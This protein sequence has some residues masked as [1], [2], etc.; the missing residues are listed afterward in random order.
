M[1]PHFW[2]ERWQNGQTG[3]H[4]GQGNALLR[5]HLGALGL[6]AGARVFVPLCG[7][8]RDIAWLLAQGFE[9]VGAELSRLAIGELFA[10]LGVVPQI[11]AAGAM[12]RYAAPGLTVYVGDIFDLTAAQLGPVDASYDRAALVALPAP[13]RARYAVHLAAI[14]AHSRQ[15]LITFSYDQSLI[16]GPPFSVQAAEVARLYGADYT[17]SCLAD[18]PAR[19]GIRGVPAQE[20]IWLLAP[21]A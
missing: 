14:S 6:P 5:A 10:E 2:H 16:Q 17:V 3:F 11:T 13:M 7:K 8:T 9:V 19:G 1:D 15:L 4:E 18:Q 21:K 12:E 20:Q